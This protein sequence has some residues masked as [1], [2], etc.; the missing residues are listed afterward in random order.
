MGRVVFLEMNK[1]SVYIPLVHGGSA[2]IDRED[3]DRVMG[4]RWYDRPDGY[5]YGVIVYRWVLLHR[6]ILNAEDGSVIDHKNRDT[7]DC[8][9]E[10]LRF[11]SFSQ[12]SMNSRKRIGGSSRFKGV[13]FESQTRKWRAEVTVN[14]KTI[15]LGRFSSEEEAAIAYNSAALDL[16]GEF[17]RINEI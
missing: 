12:N 8:R 14:Y 4:F 11:C 6:F 1:P 13:H 17:A 7:L 9:K 10:N 5:A 16:H 15:K 3:L 2:L